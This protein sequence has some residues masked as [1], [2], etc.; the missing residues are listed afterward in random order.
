SNGLKIRVSVVR[1]R[2]WAPFPARAGTLHTQTPDKKRSG[3]RAYLAGH[4]IIVSTLGRTFRSGLAP[5][6]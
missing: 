3:G 6:V 1:I 5:F 2:P 4:R